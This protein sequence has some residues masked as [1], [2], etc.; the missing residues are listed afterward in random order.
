MQCHVISDNLISELLMSRLGG[1]GGGGGCSETFVF[2]A[3]VVCDVNNRDFLAFS[4]FKIFT[5]SF[6]VS[7]PNFIV[8]FVQKC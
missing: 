4:S 7:K 2:C 8:A 6:E 3:I 5:Y 1:G